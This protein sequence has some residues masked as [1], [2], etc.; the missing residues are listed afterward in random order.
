ME[1]NKNLVVDNIQ[2]VGYRVLIS[3]YKKPNE[4]SSGFVLPENENQ[5][6]PVLGLIT[7]LGKKTFW[8]NLQVCLGIKPRYK[9]GQ[10]IYFRKY[11]VDEFKLNTPNG[12]LALYVLEENEICGL[13]N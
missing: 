1:Q 8:Q 5:G 7:L 6:M 11:S 12:E 9:I 4:T 13:V 10:W 3:I 2:P